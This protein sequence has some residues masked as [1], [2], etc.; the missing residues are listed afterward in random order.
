MNSKNKQTNE[1]SGSLSHCTLPV[2]S[3]VRTT[4]ITG[5]PYSMHGPTLSICKL[6]KEGCRH[7]QCLT[8][9]CLWSPAFCLTFPQ[10]VK[11]KKKKQP[12]ELVTHQM[13]KLLLTIYTS[14]KI[15]ES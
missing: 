13:G 12:K 10:S 14:P 15:P 2:T 4:E 7:K 5:Y 11:K 1:Q 6:D 9:L 3:T 8:H